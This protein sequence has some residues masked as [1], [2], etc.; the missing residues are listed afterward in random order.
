MAIKI[1]SVPQPDGAIQYLAFTADDAED[2]RRNGPLIF[3]RPALASLVV[4]PDGQRIW[5]F[6][7]KPRGRAAILEHLQD[8]EDADADR[9]DDDSEEDDDS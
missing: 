4:Y 2:I 8:L 3:Y 6:T 1:L 9:E 7:G 5:D